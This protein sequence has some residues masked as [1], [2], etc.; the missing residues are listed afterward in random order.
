MH[1][2][3][4]NYSNFSFLRSTGNVNFFFHITEEKVS[5]GRKKLIS[6]FTAEDDAAARGIL[7]SEDRELIPCRKTFHRVGKTLPIR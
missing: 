5:G 3:F 2:I 1:H 7:V 4:Q 6:S